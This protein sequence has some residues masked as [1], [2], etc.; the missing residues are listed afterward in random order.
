MISKSISALARPVLLL[1]L[2]AAALA[3][4]FILAGRPAA[5]QAA[6]CPCSLFPSSAV[7]GT[8]STNDPGAV[9]VGMKFTTDR[10]G[11]ITA[12][13]FY[14]GAG[15]TGVHTGSLWT[16]SGAKL[17]GVTFTGETASGW[18]QATLA[19][20]VAVAASTTYVVSY[21]APSGSYS[22]D[23]SYFGTA[24]DNSPL[25]A[26]SGTNGVYRYGSAS[27]FPSDSYQSSNY[28]VDVVFEDSAA[29]SVPVIN[30]FTASP[31]A[32]VAGQSATLSFSVQG[33]SSLS[34]DQGVGAVSGGSVSVTPSATTTYTL[35][36]ANAAGTT[37]ASVTVGVMP[38][39]PPPSSAC[40]CSLFPSS[41]VPGTPS[42]NDPGAVEVGMKFT[43]D[44]PGYITAI[45]FYKGAG[46]TG[47]HTGSLWTASGAKLAG[48]TFTGETASGW[49][50]ATLASPVAVAASTTY[51]VSYY[52]PSGS[53]SS[54]NS[55]FGTAR[56][57]S[58]LHAPSGTNG[59][60]RYGSASGFPSDSYQ[61]SN[62]WVDVVFEDSAAQSVPV[63]NS[64]TASPAAVVAGQSA[65]LSFSVQGASSLSIDQG[66]GAVSGG[67]VSVT[68]SATT[69]YT[70][71]AANAAGTTTASVTVGV[72]PAAPP[73]SNPIL[74]ITSASNK[75][76]SYYGEIL[77]AEGFNAYSMA[78]MS[79]VT[80]AVLG[81]FDEVILGD[82]PL[83]AAQ[84]SMLSDWVNGGGNLIAMKP[85]QKLASLLGIAPAAG[86]LA[87]KYFLVDTT[88]DPGKGI[89]SQ[90]M[91]FHGTADLYTLSGARAVAT[92]YSSASAPTANPAVTIRSVG[93]GRAA[94]F[95]FDLARSIVYTRQG[96]PA[97]AGQER[98]GETAVI[99]PDDL[100]YPD[101]I[102]L[103]KVAIP[104]AD[105]AQ[106]LLG[107]MLTMMSTG[108]GKSPL[109]HFWYF[110][111]M[112]KAVI[113]AA[114]DDHGTVS[115]TEDFFDDLLAASPAGCSV[116]DWTCYRA[117]S[118]LYGST[119][120][121]SAEANQY[122]TQGFD[123]GVHPD[124]GC[125]NFTS[126]AQLDSQIASELQ[127]FKAAY[128]GIK[129]QT[130]NRIHCIAW[131][132]WASV[133]KV[134]AAH[135]IR[136]DMGYYYWPAAWVQNRPGFMNGSGMPMRYVD[137]DGTII[138]VFQEAS[139]LVNENGVSYPAGITAMIDKA[140]GAEGYYGAFGTHYD[141]SDNFP[142]QMLQTVQSYNGQVQ[143]VSADQLLTWTDGRNASSFDTLS[144]SGSSLTFGVTAAPAAR[145]LY[146]LLPAD[147]AAGA[148]SSLTRNGAP[149]SFT[150]ATIKGVQYAQFQAL[151][152]NY[153]A[154]YAGAAPDTTAPT[155][156]QSV[157]AS[158]VAQTQITL[159]WASS[160][161]AVGV[162]GYHVNRNGTRIATTTTPGYT[163]T[164]LTASTS[165]SYTVSAFDAAQNESANSA[166][167][168]TSTLPVP[169]SDTTPP[170]VTGVQPA[171]NAANVAA[172]TSVTV[173]FSEPMSASSIT[174][175]TVQL[176]NASSTA[177]SG[178]VTY[179]SSSNS[180]TLVPSAALAQG[181]SYTVR[182]LGGASGA[183]D[184]AGNA[185]AATFTSSFIVAAAPTST[186]SL[187]LW[188]SNPTPAHPSDPDTASVEVGVKFT[189]DIAGK[190]YGIRF[191]KGAGNTG[192]HTGRL[193]SG[194][195]TKLGTV[196]FSNETASGWQEALF[197]TPISINANTTYVASYLAPN[198]RY[199]GDSGYFSAPVNSG[200]LHAP[201]S[202]NGVYRYTTNTAG[203]FP[204]STWQSSNYWVDVIFKAN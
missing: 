75:F 185:L 59:V 51:V 40:P 169:P 153:V 73:A 186:P 63:I 42:T 150:L 167:A 141:F 179:A 54:D 103:N 151:G 21:Y 154:T 193:W 2:L 25:H 161:D 37:T 125:T 110:P 192:T 175:A 83:T 3:G 89:V 135:G 132:D 178:I 118:W 126:Q 36:A 116:E 86:A 55:Y 165:Y 199:A 104:Q 33:A 28:W 41:A 131:S 92:L 57:N 112:G 127:G 124:T 39:A 105:E 4:F 84:A 44:R 74:V 20:P 170:T 61:S 18:Q 79:A 95:A 102:D 195:G 148:L 196:T 109:P 8:P 181:A 35:T 113:V 24:R 9:E 78:D 16:A 10:P 120:L 32:V 137:T 177:V 145:N 134:E 13:R 188:P 47:V 69:T 156:P 144:W 11:Y 15:N 168:S 129:P 164:G 43:T 171:N 133:P 176:L 34:I 143:M 180:A 85:D 31:A 197:A 97:Y 107:N 96:N 23:N 101:Y 66:V 114:S 119:G 194:T 157:T 64:F 123:L 30:S 115:G 146:A 65:T 200:T 108:P 122:Q 48:V 17:A 158:G 60:Y 174:T 159:S 19:S 106:R 58:P 71:T 53:Y 201:A 82:M 204:S 26:P 160:T 67:S 190:I 140:L 130:G 49:Q 68:P 189:S 182:V 202:G 90:T 198:G 56:D 203:A 93:A 72:M 138:D 62:Y 81:E 1:G 166:S 142:A 187:S 183:K 45:R 117:S 88:Q 128:P 98:D 173:A 152:G 147:A 162:A 7:P 46:N 139:H 50:Q 29:Q 91:Q 70:L 99:R 27:G 5:V 80:P 94:A 12:I 52:A 87:D 38:A 155:V 22:S 76:T 100:F 163:D 136:I 121:S 172:T 14:K 77:K 6:A 184:A 191:Y 111:N 149:V